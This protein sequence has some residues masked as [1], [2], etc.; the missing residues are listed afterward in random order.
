MKSS[1]STGCVLEWSGFS[2]IFLFPLAI[3]QPE[4]S[5]NPLAVDRCYQRVGFFENSCAFS[6]CFA[7]K[8]LHGCT[9]A[10]PELCACPGARDHAGE[11][12]S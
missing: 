10:G 7:W 5:I 1:I 11:S 2:L 3:V 9:C 8:R 12:F 4:F 6:I